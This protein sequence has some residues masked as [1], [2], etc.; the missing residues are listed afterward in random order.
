MEPTQNPNVP[1][2]PETPSSSG[3]VTPVA[4]ET[5]P[6]PSDAAPT[7]V[8][9]PPTPAPTPVVDPNTSATPTPAT[10]PGMQ[11]PTDKIVPGVAPNPALAGDV[12]VIEKEWVDQA[13]KVVD[14][15]KD[16]PYIQEEAVESLQQ[17]YLKKRYGRDVQK[18]DQ[19]G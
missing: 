9:A 12:D 1:V 18:P 10:N 19:E 4:P 8:P 2:N 6:R 7:A 14:Q 17:D 15:T 11:Q 13:D 5:A 16:D 3:E